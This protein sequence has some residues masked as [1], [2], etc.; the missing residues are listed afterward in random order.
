M[1]YGE[2]ESEKNASDTFK[3]RQIVKEILDFGVTEYQKIKII[4]LLSLELEDREKMNK[5][6][7]MTKSL[8]SEKGKKDNKLITSNLG[9]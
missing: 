8:I 3:C 6:S 5:L 1:K 4:Q 9:E 7:E 2:T